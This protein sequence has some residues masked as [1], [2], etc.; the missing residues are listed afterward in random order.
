VKFKSCTCA[1]HA[2]FF[3]LVIP[4]GCFLVDWASCF[5]QGIAMKGDI[6]LKIRSTLTGCA[7]A[8]A[9]LI[10]TPAAALAAPEPID[11]PPLDQA[12]I[13]DPATVTPA[14]GGLLTADGT[15]LCA[16]NPES[17]AFPN[18]TRACFASLYDSA[19]PGGQYPINS[20]DLVPF[21]QATVVDPAT[22]TIVQGGVITAE[23]VDLCTANPGSIVFPDGRYPC[24]INFVQTFGVFPT[25]EEAN[26]NTPQAEQPQAEPAQVQQLPVG[27]VDTGVPATTSD[28]TSTAT[29]LG[30]SMLGIGM[31]TA[32]IMKRRAQHGR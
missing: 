28:A 18:G 10:S 32:S 9:V 16:T 17:I 2:P 3:I 22:V 26:S 19:V 30:M 1:V 11:F 13:I 15:N 14:K 8:A 5:P 21:D 29:V 24:Y 6:T 27:G 7:L 25:P 4:R 31:L 20:P 23:G 12:T